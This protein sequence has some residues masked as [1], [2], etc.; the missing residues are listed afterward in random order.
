MRGRVRVLALFLLAGCTAG[1]GTVRNEHLLREGDRLFLAEQYLQAAGHYDA[2]LGSNAEHP[3]RAEILLR[4]GK[5]HLGAQKPDEALKA[6]DRAG[7][8][9]PEP[10]LRWEI[11]FRRGVALRMLDLWARAR[12]DFLAVST[13]PAAERGRGVG[14]DELAFETALVLFR[15]GDWKGAQ[16]RLAKVSP[17]GPKGREAQKRQGLTA[18][19]VQ[20]G[21]FEDEGRARAEAGRVRGEVRA[22]PT[23]K[24]LYLVTVGSFPSYLEAQREAE[25]LKRT[26]PQAL[27]LP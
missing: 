3:L 5:C 13:A 14:D 21:S 20:V 24:P 7:D 6:L 10:P 16:E 1:P 27:V 2:F 25:R 23:D 18:F 19:T 22:V 26:H 17:N 12:S 11:L 9:R 15:L 4:I 8:S